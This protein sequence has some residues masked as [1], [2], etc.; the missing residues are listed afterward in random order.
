MNNKVYNV[1]IFIF[2]LI[3]FLALVYW[4]APWWAY[5]FYFVLVFGLD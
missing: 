3:A 5:L 2:A 4:S 1:I